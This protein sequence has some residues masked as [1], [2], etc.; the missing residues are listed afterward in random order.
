LLTGAVPGAFIFLV[1]LA[2]IDQSKQNDAGQPAP[3][4]KTEG[5]L[6]EK[7]QQGQA[8]ERARKLAQ[9]ALAKWRRLQEKIQHP[10]KK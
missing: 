3:E 6:A 10:F 9:E 1:M 8:A 2:S 4:L 5:P 7:D